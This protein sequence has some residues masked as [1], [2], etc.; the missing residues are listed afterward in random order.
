MSNTKDLINAEELSSISE[1]HSSDEKLVIAARNLL[2]AINDWPSAVNAPEEFL[3]ILN[4]EIRKSLTKENIENYLGSL[5][6]A[7]SAWKIEAVTSVLAVFDDN[8]TKTLDEIMFNI[9]DRY[10]RSKSK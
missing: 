8:E 3:L 1:K 7:K 6:A 4:Q 9:S 10:R 2:E 5:S